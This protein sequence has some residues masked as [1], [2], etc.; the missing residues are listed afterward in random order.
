[1][2][3][4]LDGVASELAFDAVHLV[5]DLTRT[6]RAVDAVPPRPGIDG[7]VGARGGSGLRAALERALP[8][9]VAAHTP[10]ALLLDDVAGA[11][12]VGGFAWSRHRPDWADSA[13][14]RIGTATPA[15]PLRIMEGICAGF[16]PGSPNLKP[17][18]S[19]VG[20]GHA[21]LPVPPLVDPSDPIGWHAME[22]LAAVGLRRAR[23][24]DLWRE[25]SVYRVDAHFRDTCSDPLLGRIAVHEYSLAA[26]VDA[27]TLV[28][29]EL[30]ALPRV[31]P[32][33]TCPAAAGN[34]GRM[35]GQPL[36]DLRASVLAALRGTDCCTHLNDC[37]RALADLPALVAAVSR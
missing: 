26:A 22:P 2:A 24:M 36:G 3:T 18:G 10:L 33:A 37:L 1:M 12:L 31:L 19:S 14:G 25:G 35:V 4:G 23:R 9:D 5:V 21:V 30:S 34:V 15:Q 20:G 8:A 11:S 28:L 32:Y 13:R 6:I 29:L 27:A 17:D 7:L 16:R